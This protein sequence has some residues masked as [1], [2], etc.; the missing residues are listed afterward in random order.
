MET[1]VAPLGQ[2]HGVARGDEWIGFLNHLFLRPEPY[3]RTGRGVI[4]EKADVVPGG[5]RWLRILT[6]TGGS[7]MA[8][9]I[10]KAPP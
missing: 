3:R 5:T 1:R 6:I 4:D 9:M 2:F 7:S 8:P 10:F